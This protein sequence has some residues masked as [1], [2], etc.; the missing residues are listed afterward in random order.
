[1]SFSPLVLSTVTEEH[2]LFHN[3]YLKDKYDG[4]KNVAEVEEATHADRHHSIHALPAAQCNISVRTEHI[5]M[6]NLGCNMVCA[7]RS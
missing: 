4:V 7:S 3:A 6:K 2:M 5:T 1:M